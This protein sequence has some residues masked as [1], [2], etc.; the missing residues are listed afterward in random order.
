[1]PLGLKK[2]VFASNGRGDKT[3]FE[4]TYKTKNSSQKISIKNA[5]GQ[6]ELT[7]FSTILHIEKLVNCNLKDG[8]YF[9]HQ[10]HDSN[11][12]IEQLL[13]KD[14]IKIIKK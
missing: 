3:S 11:L 10:I 14:S 6:A 13:T 1:M 9:S 5:T 4:V 8:I 7:A 12:L 2:S